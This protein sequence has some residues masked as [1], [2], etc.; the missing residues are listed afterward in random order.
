MEDQSLKSRN[1]GPPSDI[2]LEGWHKPPHCCPLPGRSLA[3]SRKAELD[4][5]VITWK[6]VSAKYLILPVALVHAV[7][8][9]SK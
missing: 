2:T 6:T 8:D 4:T 7:L 1:S 5:T 9:L 3:L